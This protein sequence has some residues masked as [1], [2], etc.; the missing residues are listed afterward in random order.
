MLTSRAFL[1]ALLGFL[2]F[3]ELIEGLGS[4]LEFDDEVLDVVQN[5]IEDLL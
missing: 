2:A 3:G 1:F 4:F 5:V